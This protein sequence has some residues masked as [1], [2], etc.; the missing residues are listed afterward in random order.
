MIATTMDSPGDGTS[1]IRLGTDVFSADGAHLGSV[2]AG[3]A[4]ALVVEE[5]WF[6]VRDYQVHLSDVARVEDGQLVLSLTK[7]EVEQQR[8]LR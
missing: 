8:R 5:G 2:V 4:Y 3:V 6:L 7:T 1:G